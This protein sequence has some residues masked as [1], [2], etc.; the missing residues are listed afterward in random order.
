MSGGK[1]VYLVGLMGAGKTTVGRQLAHRLGKQFYD[2]DHEIEGRTG[3]RVGVIFDI[4]GEAGFRAREAEAIERLT[5]KNNVV[6]ATG[7]GAILNPKNGEHLV[8][9]GFVVYLHAQ[10][11]DLWQR[12]RHDQSRPL[13]RTQDPLATLKD[14]Y[15]TR[16]PLYRAIADLVIDT[17][18]QSI[19]ALMRQLLNQLPEECKQFA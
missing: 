11:R 14:L 3:V 7:G 1:N 10:P 15:E 6:L 9:R 4:E 2:S 5:Q 8:Q 16:D 19:S 12:T 13:L 18:K 17:G